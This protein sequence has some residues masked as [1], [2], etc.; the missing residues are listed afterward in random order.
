MIKSPPLLERAR[1]VE[2]VR[3]DKRAEEKGSGGHR[4]DVCCAGGAVGEESLGVVGWGVIF[5]QVFASCA[6]GYSDCD[7]TASS[8]VQMSTVGI[9]VLVVAIVLVTAFALIRNRRRRQ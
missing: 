8:N 1:A 9:V 4:G 3:G 5:S 2:A 7:D 6:V